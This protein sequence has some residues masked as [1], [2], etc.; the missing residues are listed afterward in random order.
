VKEGDWIVDKTCSLRPRVGK[1]ITMSTSYLTIH[2]LT[3]SRHEWVAPM[4]CV[5]Q[6]LQSGVWE[7]RPA[8]TWPTRIFK[9]RLY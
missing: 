1:I 7:H 8:A 9:D 5:V 6:D 4:D 2:W 3:A